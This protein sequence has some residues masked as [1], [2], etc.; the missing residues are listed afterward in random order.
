MNMALTDIFG[1]VDISPKNKGW[2][3]VERKS[4][5]RSFV[6][7]VRWPLPKAKQLNL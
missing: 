4:A 5:Y 1:T 2:D 3:V 6:H 7:R